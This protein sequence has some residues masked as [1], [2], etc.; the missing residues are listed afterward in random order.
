M[1]SDADISAV[2]DAYILGK[3]GIPKTATDNVGLYYGVRPDDPNK[4]TLYVNV[5]YL[6]TKKLTVKDGTE[7]VFSA[8]VDAPEHTQIGGFNVSSS[9]LSTGPTSITD[10][11]NTGLFL[12][13]TGIGFIDTSDF[14]GYQS[15]HLTT[16]K[17]PGNVR[18]SRLNI[19]DKP[20]GEASAKHANEYK[21]TF[22]GDEII[23]GRYNFSNYSWDYEQ[24]T[25]GSKLA[26][27]SHENSY[28][29][30]II[31]GCNIPERYRYTNYNITSYQVG[32]TNS[33]SSSTSFDETEFND[34]YP[35][36]DVSLYMRNY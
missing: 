15:L 14:S 5:D 19:V 10:T 13:G 25:V 4:K 27:Q 8:D 29:T 16:A 32:V 30:T 9:Y 3:L 36:Y 34:P 31:N 24:S 21:G 22:K 18:K 33:V 28:T 11:T 1:G 17:D 6:T 26:I 12:S 2:D 20:S 23:I 35:I 7:I